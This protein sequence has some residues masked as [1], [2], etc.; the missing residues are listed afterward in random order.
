MSRVLNDPVVEP[1]FP[2]NPDGD[3]EDL[4]DDQKA[5]FV[6][7]NS[8]VHRVGMA[9]SYLANTDW[10]VSRKSETGTAIPEN[11]L[12]LRAQARIDASE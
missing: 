10:Y 2:D 12:A 8:S 4:T 11:I 6:A 7:M 9:K 5:A 1:Q 3:F